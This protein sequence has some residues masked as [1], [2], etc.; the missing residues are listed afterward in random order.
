MHYS[1]SKL[2]QLPLIGT[3][4]NGTITYPY[5]HNNRHILRWYE[6]DLLVSC[7]QTGF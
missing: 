1:F 6:W 3:F 7:K 4:K 2:F 5:S